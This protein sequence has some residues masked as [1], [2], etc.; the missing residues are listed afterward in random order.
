MEELQYVGPGDP[1]SSWC[2]FYT[3]SVS[4]VFIP[5]LILL[6]SLSV[7]QQPTPAFYPSSHHLSSDILVYT[8][9]ETPASP[10]N[11]CLDT[12]GSPH[13]G[14]SPWQPAHTSSCVNTIYVMLIISSVVDVYQCLSRRWQCMSHPTV[15]LAILTPPV[16][17]NADNIRTLSSPRTC[18][19]TFTL[20]DLSAFTQSS[21]IPHL[22]P[23]HHLLLESSGQPNSNVFPNLI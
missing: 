10:K 2:P 19:T 20:I 18:P 13:L 17:I 6:L 8:S 4:I 11:L 12:D 14:W 21:S 3:C 9:P 1:L 16:L 7:H 15:T 22:R 5:K 23:F